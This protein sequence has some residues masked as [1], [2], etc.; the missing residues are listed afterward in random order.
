MLEFLFILLM[1]IESTIE[2]KW[3]RQ[4]EHLNVVHENAKYNMDKS[5]VMVS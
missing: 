3:I 2:G 5:G 1:L 4:M